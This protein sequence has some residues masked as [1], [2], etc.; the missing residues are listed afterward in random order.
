MAIE[1]PDLECASFRGPSYT[2]PVPGCKGPEYCSIKDEATDPT[3]RKL[4]SGYTRYKSLVFNTA[5][6]ELQ[7]AALRDCGATQL[8]PDFVLALDSIHNELLRQSQE[9]AE[10]EAESKRKHKEAIERSKKKARKM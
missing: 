8:L 9:R 10:K 6:A 7:L 5:P 2:C 3:V 1:D 4:V